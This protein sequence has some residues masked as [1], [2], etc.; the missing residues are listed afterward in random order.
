MQDTHDVRSDASHPWS[1]HIEVRYVRYKRIL[2]R[3]ARL[4][5]GTRSM[6]SRDACRRSTSTTFDPTTR[7][8][9]RRRR[10]RSRGVRDLFCRVLHLERWRIF[11]HGSVRSSF[12]VQARRSIVC[13]SLARV[14]LGYDRS[15]RVGVRGWETLLRHHVTHLRL[16]FKRLTLFFFHCTFRTVGSS[17]GLRQLLHPFHPPRTIPDRP[18]ACGWMR[19]RRARLRPFFSRSIPS[20]FRSLRSVLVASFPSF[21]LPP[22]RVDVLPFACRGRTLARMVDAGE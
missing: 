11:L 17:H 13:Q 15:T 2:A 5:R 19:R 20:S 22:D 21:P 16:R 4:G 7:S 1:S 10:G 6:P 14:L 12:H 3:T 8:R 18:F 9:S